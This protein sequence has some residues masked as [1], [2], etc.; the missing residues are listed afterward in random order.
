MGP[1]CESLYLPR[2]SIRIRAAEPFQMGLELSALAF[3]GGDFFFEKPLREKPQ[4]P[5]TTPPPPTA[6]HPPGLSLH[7]A[8][9]GINAN[10]QSA[11]TVTPETPQ[12]SGLPGPRTGDTKWK[13]LIDPRV[14]GPFWGVPWEKESLAEKG[15][16]TP[17]S[18]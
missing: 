5:E 4:P 8:I 1:A 14:G 3:K 16:E 11:P 18:L 13:G 2:G 15:S 7:V 12:K 10:Q 6:S 9:L 17:G